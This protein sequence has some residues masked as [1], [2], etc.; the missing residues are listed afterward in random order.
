MGSA[1]GTARTA[2]AN[3]AT[4]HTNGTSAIALILPSVATSRQRMLT[5]N[6]AEAPASQSTKASISCLRAV[7]GV[8]LLRNTRQHAFDSYAERGDGHRAALCRA[9]Q[10]HV[11][12]AAGRERPRRRK[13]VAGS[14]KHCRKNWLGGAVGTLS[15]AASRSCERGRGDFG[16]QLAPR[17]QTL[18][19]PEVSSWTALER[20][21][22]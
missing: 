13:S 11:R 14:N 12:S 10:F 16:N 5:A 20:S 8:F 6:A 18:R 9:A 2:P 22:P 4:V 1:A 7:T 17:D 21:Q 3:S 19:C 15:V